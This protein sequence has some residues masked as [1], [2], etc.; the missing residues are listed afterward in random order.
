MS[1]LEATTSASRPSSPPRTRATN[2][3]TVLSP[4]EPGSVF[5]MDRVMTSTRSCKH[6]PAN[7]IASGAIACRGQRIQQPCLDHPGHHE[8]DEGCH[9]FGGL[10]ATG[11]DHVDPD[12]R[13]AVV[14]QY[15]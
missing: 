9:G 7:G 3:P 2:G 13:S 5:P 1:T 10:T 8:I 4:W 12:A 11:I 14:R 6:G 15:F